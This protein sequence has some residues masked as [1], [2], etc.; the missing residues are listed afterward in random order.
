VIDMTNLALVAVA[1]V[2]TYAS[3]AAALVFL[4]AP[5]GRLLR[6]VERLPA[7]LFAGLAILALVGPDATWPDPPAACAAAGALAAAP[8]RNVALTLTAGLTAFGIGT[9]LT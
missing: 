2:L 7:P 4:P 6:F 9:L 1:A 8:W 5:T 3:R